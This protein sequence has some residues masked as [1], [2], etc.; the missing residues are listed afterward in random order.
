MRDSM[1]QPTKQPDLRRPIDT[2]ARGL[3]GGAYEKGAHDTPGRLGCM[4][5]I[6]ARS[7]AIKGRQ[8]MKKPK[9]KKWP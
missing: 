9:L 6:R 4:A 5:E 8:G 1:R 7:R 3:R 2:Q